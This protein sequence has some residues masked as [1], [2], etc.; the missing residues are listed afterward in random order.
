MPYDASSKSTQAEAT[1]TR[2]LTVQSRIRLFVFSCGCFILSFILIVACAFTA[3]SQLAVQNHSFQQFQQE[4]SVPIGTLS[5]WDGALYL[6]IIQDGYE[7]SENST[8]NVAF[9]PGYPLVAAS[10]SNIT[11]IAPSAALLIV[12]NICGLFFFILFAVYV[13]DRPSRSNP[14]GELVRFSVVALAVWPMGLFFR[15]AYSESLFCLLMLAAML[16]MHRSWR[17]AY[18]AIVVGA[19]TA[20]RPVGVALVPVFV[21]WLWSTKERNRERMLSV[22]IWGPVSCWGLILYALFLNA[23]WNAPFAFARAQENW[24]VRTT[25]EAREYVAALLTL[26]PIWSVYVPA[27]PTYWRNS[28]LHS[29]PVLSLHFMNPIFFELTVVLVLVGIVMRWLNWRESLLSALLLLIPYTTHAYQGLMYSQGRYAAVV[30]PVY[31][32]LGHLSCR[33]PLWV[34]VAAFTMS[35]CMLCIYAGMFACWYRIF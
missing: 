16:G 25:P 17:P 15:T 30:F 28:E 10:L 21:L 34:S 2:K 33:S 5:A 19:A 3:H 29:C 35:L 24:T 14:R 11:G 31:I 9:F 12:S 8:S 4:C 18:I 6:K 20:V 22:M 26:E 27:T 13:S 23:V 1:G 7:Y 32:V